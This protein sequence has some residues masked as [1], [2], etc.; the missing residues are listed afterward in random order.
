MTTAS[1]PAPGAPR[2]WSRLA[3][4]PEARTVLGSVGLRLGVGALA[5]VIAF[6]YSLLTLIRD[7]GLDTPLAYL[8]LVPLIAVGVALYLPRDTTGPDI[9]D[10]QLDHI[11]G[12]PL[13]LAA[14]LAIELL[15][16]R[17]STVYWTDRLDLLALPVFVFGVSVLLFGLRSTWRYRA[18][19]AFLFMAWSYPYT[20]IIERTVDATTRV[21]IDGLKGALSVLP[22]AHQASPTDDSIFNVPHGGGSFPVSIASACA[23]VNSMIGFIVVGVAFLTIVRRRP[24]RAA[25]AAAKADGT[26]A[27]SI[28]RSAL[29]RKLAWLGA[30]LVLVWALNVVRLMIVLWAGKTWGEKVALD[31]L[32]PYIGVVMFAL[33]I[34]ALLLVMPF[35][36][37]ELLSGTPAP[38]V[39]TDAEGGTRRASRR[40]RLAQT[41]RSGSRWRVSAITVVVA[42]VLVGVTDASFQRYELT[43]SDLGT[44]RL[45]SFDSGPTAVPGYSA[46]KTNDY[47]WVKQY[48]GGSSSWSRYSYQSTA[49]AGSAITADVIDGSNLGKFNAYGIEACYTFH[50]YSFVA[51]QR[52]SLGGGVDGYQLSYTD[53]RSHSAWDVLYWVWAVKGASGHKRYE[54]VTL[55]QPR[56]SVSDPSSLAP[57]S[58]PLKGV[59]S[60]APQGGAVAATGANAG[61][62]AFAQQLVAHQPVATAKPATPGTTTPGTTTPGTTT[63]RAIPNNGT[64]T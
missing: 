43:A 1:L 29:G 30:G 14:V 4:S 37:L 52:V 32:H 41:P 21:T 23:G 10:R 40:E 51:Q 50:G 31:G 26:H 3:A 13:V 59:G 48:F 38:R 8:G 55:L 58:A 20:L 47:D 33:A 9:H 42:A 11:V 64:T 18:P 17:L 45:A 25:R 63:K 46:A 62:F 53:P 22:F 35:F 54:R 16:D 24:G 60:S 34:V 7:L 61:L 19:I 28:A 15:P 44:P 56:G 5:V 27:H 39:A 12:L 36:G 6:H 57:Q 2:P 49:L